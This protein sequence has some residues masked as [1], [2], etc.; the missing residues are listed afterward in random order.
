MDFVVPCT[1]CGSRTTV[2]VQTVTQQVLCEMCGQQ[3]VVPLTGVTAGHVENDLWFQ[4][5][6]GQGNLGQV[7][8][9]KNLKTNEKLALKVLTPAI[10]VEPEAVQAY[11][12]E[13]MRGGEVQV[14]RWHGVCVNSVVSGQYCYGY[15]LVAGDCLSQVLAE[16]P[17]AF[18]IADALAIV[19][20]I[21]KTLGRV[22][23]Q[24]Q[25][26]HGSLH[27]GNILLDEDDKPHLLE[28]CNFKRRLAGGELTMDHLNYAGTV[29][30]FMS[31]EQAQGWEQADPRIDVYA[32]GGVLFYMVA[33]EKPV[34]GDSARDVLHNHVNQPP[35]DVRAFNDDAGNDVAELIMAM[36]DGDVDERMQDWK[37]VF[38][39]A[40]ACRQAYTSSNLTETVMA[41]APA[42]KTR[43]TRRAATP[44]PRKS[45]APWVVVIVLIVLVGAIAGAAALVLAQK[46]AQPEP[47][48]PPPDKRVETPDDD[49]PAG[50]PAERVR[51]QA[52]YLIDWYRKGVRSQDETIKRLE[53]FRD[54]AQ[55]AADKAHVQNLINQVREGYIK[56]AEKDD[57]RP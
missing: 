5:E 37:E 17:D 13:L 49:A 25:L 14:P 15:P 42:M 51:T 35:P 2:D 3:F 7:F 40:K 46:E 30:D 18:T 44:P 36:M 12:N 24:H 31:P 27:P 34:H 22:W 48:D 33:G 19:M 41:P 10:C 45:K 26:I 52:D 11:I 23:Q 47:Q 50:Q 9:G 4:R 39:T 57:D 56:P 38:G 54:E 28:P 43:A 29:A 20:R 55:S 1:I 6:L 16:E 21:A 32:L 8:E 53:A